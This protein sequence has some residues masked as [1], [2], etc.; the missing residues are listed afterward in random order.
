MNTVFYF[1]PQEDQTHEHQGNAATAALSGVK[2]AVPQTATGESTPKKPVRRKKVRT[3]QKQKIH[4]RFGYY[5]ES[6]TFHKYNAAQQ[7]Y[8][9]SV[10]ASLAPGEKLGDDVTL[11][12]LQA[13]RAAQRQAE[14]EMMH[15][16]FDV[17]IV[18][19]GSFFENNVFYKASKTAGIPGKDAGLKPYTLHSDV[20]VTGVIFLC[21]FLLAYV[22]TVGHRLILQKIKSIFQER[23]RQSLFDSEDRTGVSYRI[24]LF[25]LMSFMWGLLFFDYVQNDNPAL[26]QEVSPYILLGVDVGMFIGFFLFKGILYAFIN[27]V[28]F[29]RNRNERWMDVYFFVNYLT[30]I[31]LYPLVLLVVYFDLQPQS[32]ILYVSIVA[33]IYIIV[34]FYK[35][36]SIFFREKYGFFYLIVYFCTLEIIPFLLLW[37]VLIVVNEC[38]L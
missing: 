36:F 14:A 22:I 30:G 16:H 38:L 7:H 15:H 23:E 27:W 4:G 18:Y 37:K 11:E 17:P 34:L 32:V 24:Y 31:V 26:F 8:M 20:Y 21:F 28:F 5:D 19:K 2:S 3:V 9:D 10:F 13:Q 35:C 6:G 1:H 33:I 25:L 12:Q 29:D